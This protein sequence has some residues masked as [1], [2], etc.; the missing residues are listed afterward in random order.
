MSF[1]GLY[2]GSSGIRASQRGL[3]VSSHNI[4]NA[5]TDGYTRQRVELAAR[6]SYTSPDGRI[7]TGVEVEDVARLRDGFLD[8]RW[9]TAAGERAHTTARA[10]L[11]SSLEELT[12]EPDNGLSERFAGLWD[13]A[14]DWANDPDAD[15]ARRQVLTELGSI[16]E[17]LRTT[18]RDWQLLGEDTASRRDTLVDAVND[19]LAQVDEL[20]RRIANADPDRIGPELHDERDLLLDELAE[21]LGATTRI[22]ADGRAIVTSGDTELVTADGHASLAID[23]GDGAFGR[24]E[25]D[26][27]AG[28]TLGE[29]DLEDA[30]ELLGLQRALNEDLVERRSELDDLA[31]SFASEINHI[32]TVDEDGDPFPDGSELLTFDAADPAGTIELDDGVGPDDLIAG[33]T[34]NHPANDPTNARRLTDLRD[35]S[36][37]DA[38]SEDPLEDQVADLTVGLAGDVRALRN[39]AEAAGDVASGAAR[40]RSSEHGVSLDEEMVDLVRYQR[41]LEASSRVMTTVDEALDVLVNRTGTVGR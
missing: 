17:G 23:S 21:Q 33:A 11:L 30:G 31:T 15:A 10:E 7:G 41:S 12:G 27:P 40:A 18:A 34:G 35:A 32:N 4:A 28:D 3:D 20:N 38:T 19:N 26:T 14:E 37:I 16:A 6:P 8:D 5:N 36:A 25:L 29:D 39:R 9:R 22:D 24:L 1:V 2:T 13:A